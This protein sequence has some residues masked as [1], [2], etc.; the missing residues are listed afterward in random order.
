[1]VGWS[2]DTG[3]YR[4][5]EG[6]LGWLGAITASAAVPVAATSG[7]QLPLTVS[8]CY[9][10]CG[11]TNCTNTIMKTGENTGTNKSK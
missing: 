4:R 6:G 2:E 3:G 1:M 10:Y 11:C 7:H 9:S 5:D 8:D